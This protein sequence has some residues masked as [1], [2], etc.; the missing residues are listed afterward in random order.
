MSFP[1][2]ALAVTIFLIGRVSVLVKEYFS[3]PEQFVLVI[4]VLL[5]EISVIV[6]RCISDNEGSMVFLGFEH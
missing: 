1:N 3:G 5:Y 4:A 2:T 6:S